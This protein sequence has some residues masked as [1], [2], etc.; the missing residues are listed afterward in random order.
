MCNWK[1][2]VSNLQ[3]SH[4]VFWQWPRRS[5]CSHFSLLPMLLWIMQVFLLLHSFPPFLF[6]FFRLTP[7][8]TFHF[9]MDSL[10]ELSWL[11]PLCRTLQK[12]HQNSTILRPHAFPAHWCPLSLNYSVH[13]WLWGKAGG[14]LTN[15]KSEKKN[16][17]QKSTP[18]CLSRR[19][20]D[21]CVKKMAKVRTWDLHEKSSRQ[22]FFPFP[23]LSL[24]VGQIPLLFQLIC[25]TWGTSLVQCWFRMRAADK[26]KVK[27]T[28]T[29][30][31]SLQKII[32]TWK[33]TPE[34]SKR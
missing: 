7:G 33:R 18:E 3:K 4:T 15:P 34:T 20:S 9:L 19:Q 30:C 32:A 25:K 10:T 31:S 12:W 5:R 17:N 8:K 23:L 1:I 22:F 28:C 14:F 11:K 29:C 24:T 2:M 16:E 26:G 21:F 6:F 13:F 27:G